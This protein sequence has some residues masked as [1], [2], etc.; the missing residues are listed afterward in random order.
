L[1]GAYRCTRNL[2]PKKFHGLVQI[3]PSPV[4]I[5]ERAKEHGNEIRITDLLSGVVPDRPAVTAGLG[6]SSS[7]TPSEFTVDL[8]SFWAELERGAK[9]E[10]T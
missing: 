3:V 6:N 7:G 4:F 2:T 9:R 1:D 10:L 8:P 5:I